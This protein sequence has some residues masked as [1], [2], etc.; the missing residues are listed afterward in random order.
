MIELESVT[1]IFGNGKVVLQDINLSLKA[2][3]TYCLLGKNGAGKSTLINIL[4]GL[5]LPDNSKAVVLGEDTRQLS[6]ATKQQLG[7][8]HEELGLIDEITGHDYLTLMGKIYG[9]EAAEAKQ[10]IQQLTTYFFENQT[11][12]K[13]LVRTYST[14]MRKRLAFCAAVIHTPPILLLD[15]PFSGLDPL[16][17]NKL[18]DF[19]KKYQNGQRLIFLSSHDLNYVEKVCSHISVLHD[20]QLLTNSTLTEFTRASTISLEDALVAL[21]RGENYETNQLDWL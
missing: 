18:I 6:T 13:K 21:L 11:D 15:E 20:G 10:K 4:L 19:L 7:V 12:L 16:A 3:Q 1:K 14:G 17:A 9:M 5:V 8:V 2:G